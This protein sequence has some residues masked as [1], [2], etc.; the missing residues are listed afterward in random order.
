MNI[1]ESFLSHLEQK[2]KD[3]NQFLLPFREG[4]LSFSLSSLS[5]NSNSL[6][7]FLIAG[8]PSKSSPYGILPS[9]TILILRSMSWFSSKFLYI[10]RILPMACTLIFKIKDS[11][12]SEHCPIR[13]FYKSS[14]LI[15]SSCS[16]LYSSYAIMQ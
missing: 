15:S 1:L 14:I 12:S 6:K 7:A 9:L 3:N 16:Y 13:I 5:A 4:L 2:F 11:F 8:F 10:R